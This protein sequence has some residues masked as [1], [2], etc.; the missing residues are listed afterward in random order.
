MQCTQHSRKIVARLNKNVGSMSSNAE[1]VHTCYIIISDYL[2]VLSLTFTL[3][4]LVNKNAVN[5]VPYKYNQA[6]H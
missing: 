1:I 6:I 5:E 4:I 2:E 3:A